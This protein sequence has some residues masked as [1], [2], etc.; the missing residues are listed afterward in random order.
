MTNTH[1]RERQKHYYCASET[2]K[3]K[4]QA[5]ITPER[6][7]SGAAHV[8]QREVNTISTKLSID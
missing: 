1:V 2:T 6:S 5:L 4:E 7:E 8:W 3:P